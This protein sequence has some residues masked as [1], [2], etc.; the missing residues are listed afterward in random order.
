MGESSISTVRERIEAL[1]Q[2]HDNLFKEIIALPDS[3]LQTILVDCLEG[4]K[5]ASTRPLRDRVS[6]KNLHFIKNL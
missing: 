5:G 2:L 4:D 6:D 3:E 1:K